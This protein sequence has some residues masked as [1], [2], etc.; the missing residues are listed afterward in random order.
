MNAR[1]SRVRSAPSDLRS[2]Q[3][4]LDSWHRADGA[5]D[6]AADR[7]LRMEREERDRRL[8][9]RARAGTLRHITQ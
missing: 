2:L 5:E 3:P 1:A 9:D 8:V 4:V 6:A 7:K